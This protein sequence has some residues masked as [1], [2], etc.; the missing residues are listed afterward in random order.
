MFERSEEAR[1]ARRVDRLVARLLAG[2]RLGTTPSDAPELSAIMMA[3][4]MAGIREPYARMSPAFRRRMA[5]TGAT[6]ANPRPITRRTALV[7]GLAAAGG[8]AVGAAA[9]QVVPDHSVNRPARSGGAL[10]S[11][12]SV[13]PQAAFARWVDVGISVAELADGRPRRVTAGAIPVFVVRRG[14]D[15]LALSAYCTHQPCALVWRPGNR[16]L[17]CPCHNQAFDLDGT[18][19]ASS[20]TLPP[21]P[22]ARVRIQ[23]GRV[24]VLGT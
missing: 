5:K 23:K 2:H 9:D 8:I 11:S 14:S 18:P 10:R 22:M 6:G 20:Y 16:T 3:A 15:V 7:A 21:L 19:L 4:R 24:E 13:E 12:P 17:G 1:R